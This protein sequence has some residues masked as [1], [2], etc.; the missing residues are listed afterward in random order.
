MALVLA[1]TATGQIGVSTKCEG[2]WLPIVSAEADYANVMKDGKR[3]D[4]MWGGLQVKP[5]AEFGPGM[6]KVD[7][8]VADLDPLKDA[9]PE[10][11]AKPGQVLFRYTAQVTSNE[12]MDNCYALLVFV[13][14]GSVGTNLQPIGR[15]RGGR[16]H[17]V[18][19]EIGSHV[20]SV[21]GLH[22]FSGIKEVRSNEVPAAYDA[23]ELWASLTRNAKGVSA[24]ELCRSEER[25]EWALSRDGRFLATSRDRGKYFAI[26]VYDLASMNVVCE[27]P[28]DKEYRQVSGLTWVS[29]S[30]L[31]FVCDNELRLA[32]IGKRS[33]ATLEKEVYA[34]ITSV[35]AKPQLV[36]IVKLNHW[37]VVTVVIDTVSRKTVD[38]D[39]LNSGWTC[40]DA[41]GDPRV[42]SEYEGSQNQ[43]YARIGKSTRW[44]PLDKTVKQPGLTFS[45]RADRMLDRKAEV[46]N[47]GADGDTA[48]ISSRADSDMFQLAE[49]SLSKGVIVRT[50]AT[51]PKYDLTNSD[52]N[53][54]RI[55]FSNATAEPVGMVYNGEKP[56]VVWFDPGYVE[57]QK[58]VERNFPGELA[59]PVAWTDDG[60]TFIYSISSDRNPGAYYAF[61]PGEKKLVALFDQGE[62]LKGKTLAATT[63][64]TFGAR[65]GATISGYL[66]M[67]PDQ[68]AGPV[69]L[70]VYIHGGP[71][72]RDSWGFHATTQF[73]ATR[74][75]AVLQVNFR[76]S[77]G[78]GAKYQLAGLR[79]R[80]DTVVLDD[81]ADGVNSLV[82]AGTVDPKRI[83]VMGGSFGGW[84][85]YM[86]LIKYPEL[87]RAG[88]AIAAV[89]H[90]R[91]QQRDN[92]RDFDKRFA[93]E[94]WDDILGHGDFEQNEKY[95]DPFVRAAEIRQ[96]IYIMH[97]ERDPVVLSTQ[98]GEI[99]KVLKKSNPNVRSM[100]FPDASHTYWP[101]R[102]RI[103]M[104]N[105]IESFL[106][107]YLPAEE[108]PK[109]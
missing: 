16:G 61:R 7:N 55:L 17:T 58:A 41:N 36:V 5:A 28:A 93:Y 10:E 71:M 1:R 82:K 54:C 3:K 69:P 107:T 76:G 25:P 99:L 101:E 70:V 29:G 9:K 74:G 24:V 30:A 49:Y 78:Y 46:L 75:Y 8:I 4:V 63:P 84:A 86:S 23:N 50:I 27:I 34:L 103:T 94:V 79:A 47:I 85:T 60:S 2:A 83:A 45:Y 44:V 48:Y 62:R 33:V 38:W 43:F 97:G 67:P 15:L 35:A 88:V 105:E 90:F 96:P 14:N 18:K 19:I 81:I 98:A 31:A 51:H 68:A 77:S 12:D 26:V 73:L 6:V 102:D 37:S 39:S 20:D 53:E 59:F 106:R 104:L 52:Y 64:I 57:V 109:S 65:D 92:H 32:D 11:R 100:S 108:K 87:Y 80:L 72:A 89:S 22:V 95:I 13:S 91:Q 56:K 66:T 40:F 42:R 21:S